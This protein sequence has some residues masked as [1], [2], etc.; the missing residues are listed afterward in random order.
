MNEFAPSTPRP[1][2]SSLVVGNGKAHSSLTDPLGYSLARKPLRCTS[3]HQSVLPATRDTTAH[4]ANGQ[5]GRQT[6][7]QDGDGMA[8]DD[9]AVSVGAS[10]GA[11]NAGYEAADQ[12]P[13]TS[14][15]EESESQEYAENIE[16][17]CMSTARSQIRAKT[18]CNPITPPTLHTASFAGQ[19]GYVGLG[20]E[21]VPGIDLHKITVS[22]PVQRRSSLLPKS[23]NFQRIAAALM[24]ESSP[25]ET[26]TKREA[27]VAHLLRD[28]DSTEDSIAE[29]EVELSL[30]R[31]TSLT[32]FSEQARDSVHLHES[33]E[34]SGSGA[35]YSPRILEE[36]L[37][38]SISACEFERRVSE[39]SPVSPSVIPM[40]LERRTKRKG[41]QWK[42]A[43]L[44]RV[45]GEDRFE[46]YHT[47]KRRAVSPGLSS[48]NIS[49]SP[50]VSS[51]IGLSG[52][53]RTILNIQD[54]HDGLLKMTLQ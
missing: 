28:N 16:D 48:P 11:S 10:A 38:G 3:L 50:P 15:D 17:I 40:A 34:N 49:G 46:P 14:S 36:F 4:A 47:F 42:L 7:E 31:Q 18:K 33:T 52:M 5:D 27:A 13:A 51:P 35:S 2:R 44:T 54:T 21:R 22:R 1:R 6:S 19:A 8:Y 9:D 23:R 32:S 25:M 24:E 29:E 45:H 53:K 12:D 26:E 20:D 37:L 39:G 30:S 43:M 41:M